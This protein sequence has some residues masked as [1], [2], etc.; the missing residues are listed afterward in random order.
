MFLENFT[1]LYV[2]DDQNMQ[3][4]MK[5]FLHDE[6]KEF[7]QANNGEEGLAVYRD[8]KA[9][10]ILSD[11]RMPKMTG[12][13]MAQIIKE[14]DKHQPVLLLSAFEDIEVLKDAINIGINGFVAKPVEDI[15]KL[16]GMLESI[17]FN[18][19]NE[20][21]A[22]NLKL[23]EQK[24]Q[25]QMRLLASVFANSQE[26]ILIADRN[27]RIIDVNPAC[28]KISGYTRDEVIGNTPA[29]F[30]SGK[31][32]PEF[33]AKMWKSLVDSGHW[34]GEMMNRKKT[35]E[36]YSERLSIDTVTDNKGELQHYVAVF[37]DMTYIKKHEAELE[38]I[39]YNDILTKLPN[40]LLLHDRMKQALSKANRNE[41]MLAV[42][43]LDL[44]GFKA[45]NDNF[46][47]TAGDMV[48]IELA[49]RLED[50]VRSGDTVARIGGDEFILLI[51]DISTIDEL[52]QI[53]NR[54]LITISCSYVLSDDKTVNVDFISASIGVTIYPVDKSEADILL[55]HADQAMYLA[56]QRG[57]NQYKFFQA[58][59]DLP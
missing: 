44:D 36:I 37:Y 8:K 42:C 34:N 23:E 33:Y 25:D 15:T 58:I 35:G 4:Y 54:I 3:S 14:L 49:R 43:Y 16:L 10:I 38:Y 12:L 2:E 47:H 19:Q 53:L 28:L 40:R 29:M 46:S 48:L 6:V 9:D 31:N 30:G 57:K 21:D 41:K 18:L 45:V 27:N 26:G 24:V 1:L 13:K 7:Y 17:A 39:A 20:V 55:R 59:D 56:K 5:S 50:A 52:K 22:K 11:I 32:P 51:T